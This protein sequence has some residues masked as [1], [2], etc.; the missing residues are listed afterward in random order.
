[1][2]E[3]FLMP[4]MCC[5]RRRSG[6]LEPTGLSKRFLMRRLCTVISREN[7]FLGTQSAFR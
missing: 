7:I 4:V 1:M 6:W 3:A 5:L 2:N